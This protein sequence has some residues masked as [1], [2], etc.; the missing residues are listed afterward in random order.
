MKKRMRLKG[1]SEAEIEK[2]ERIIKRAERRKHPHTRY[3]E[4]SMFWF[5]LATGVL[6]TALLSFA[7]IPVLV[8]GTPG[9]GLMVA[10]FFGLLLGIMIRYISSNMHWLEGHHHVSI[11]FTIPIVALFNFFIVAVTV[12]NFNQFAGLPS[13]HNPVLVGMTYFIA[14]LIPFA[15]SVV[16]KGGAK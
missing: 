1:R 12:N 6:G 11:T 4:Q 3:I 15:S 10:F 13:Q 14:F 2:V 16:A 9:Q 5:T 8:A 7:I